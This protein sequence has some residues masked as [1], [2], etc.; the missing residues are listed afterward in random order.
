MA[1]D[2]NQATTSRD[3]MARAERVIPGGVNSPVR[4]FRAVGG[5][6][7]VL[8]RGEGAH[9][10]DADG[11]RYLDFVGSWGP[12]LFGHADPETIR[13]VQAAAERGTTFGAPTAAEVEL[14]ETVSR[15]MPGIEQ[16]R[17]VSSG[18]EAAMS[19]LRLA[20]AASRRDK[21]VKFE[22]CYHGHADA[23][24]IQAGSGAA[25][26]G[27]P[28]SPGVPPGTAMDTLVAPYNDLEAVERL[29]EQYGAEIGAIIVEPVAG[30]MGCVPPAD[31]FL[32]GLRAI[33]DREGAILIF[34]EVITGFRVARGGAS[35]RFGVRPDLYVL[36]KVLG[37]GLPLAGFGGS[38]KLMSL[39]APIGPV[40]QAGTLSGNPLAT[41]AGLVALR[42][43]EQEIG[44][45]DR[46]EELGQRLEKGV[47]TALAGSPLV[48]RVASE[49]PT[50]SRVGSLW[51]LFFSGTTPRSW[52]SV[53][54]ANTERFA[55][56]FRAML[57]RGIYLPPSQFESA[58]LSTAHTESDIDV[59]VG[60]LRES[61]AEALA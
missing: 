51:T 16:L 57:R 17:L 5:E 32:P 52:E 27:T 45:F 33:A 9:V 19:A 11:R 50:F 40:Y 43:I 56:Y 23:F 35:E 44:L 28:S 38:A 42:R 26:F 18:T 29:F 34:D 7:L 4:A 46:L 10:I 55:R 41:A 24:L 53:R 47:L 15:L 36:G 22:G 1:P 39:L 60:A 3:W 61:I 49:G 54:G 31:G 8:M 20:R 21:V 58:F 48:A 25:T 2:A 13:A 30:N 37:G 6:P 12:L 14:A 59:A